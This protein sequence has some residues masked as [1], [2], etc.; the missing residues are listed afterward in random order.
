MD[1]RNGLSISQSRRLA[2]LPSSISDEQVSDL[3]D[4]LYGLARVA[5]SEYLATSG[6]W[7]TLEESERIDT[8][9]R[10]A[11]LQF[12]GGLSPSEADRIALTQ[13]RRHRR[14]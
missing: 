4:Q 3:L 1:S 7:E 10:A 14:Q 12:E 6:A 2:D 5:V 13:S 8:E 9:E 11:I